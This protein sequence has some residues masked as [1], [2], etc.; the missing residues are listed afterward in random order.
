MERLVHVI[1]WELGQAVDTARY[2]D[3]M[4]IFR[5]MYEQCAANVLN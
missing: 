1:P 4:W 3:E 2:Q 5:T